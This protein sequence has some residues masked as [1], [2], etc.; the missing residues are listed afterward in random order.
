[1]IIGLTGGIASGKST[2]SDYFKLKGY[3]VYDADLIAKEITKTSEVERELIFNFGE[4]ILDKNLKIDRKKLKELVFSDRKKLEI[5]N[6][7]VHPKVY[8]FFKNIYLKNNNKKEVVI[9]DI[10]LLF[11]SGMEKICDRIILITANKET[12]IKRIIER[13]SISREFAEKIISSQMPDE[14]KIKKSDIIIQNDGTL[15]ELIKKIER[16][17]ESL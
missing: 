4:K 10:P 6:E 9:F 1:M 17:C 5:L 13:D 15:E 14:E 2:V 7:I 12:K 8:N 3:K 16:F 11:E